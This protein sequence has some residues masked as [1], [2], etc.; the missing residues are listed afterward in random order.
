MLVAVVAVVAEV[1]EVAVV[2]DP[3]VTLA[4]SVQVGAEPVEVMMRLEAPM[5][6][7]LS[8]VE[9]VA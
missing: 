9:P 2:A 6:S 3:T 5:P 8:V 7:L 4:G 1:A